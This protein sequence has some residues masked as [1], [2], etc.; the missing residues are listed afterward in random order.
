MCQADGEGEQ[1]DVDQRVGRRH[2]LG[3][4]RQVGAVEYGADQKYPGQQSE[5]QGHDRSVDQVGPVAI[6]AAGMNKHHHGDAEKTVRGQ[7]EDI[8]HRRI[9]KLAPSSQRVGVPHDEP[10]QV[11]RLAGEQN[12]PRPEARGPVDR[13]AH[14]HGAERGCVH[15][16]E[17]HPLSQRR[18]RQ[19]Q[20]AHRGHEADGHEAKAMLWV[21]KLAL[22]GC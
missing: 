12:R 20:E 6:G 19:D 1:H 15:R 13:Y 16:H 10:H 2:R 9:G 17:Q 8:G 22:R 21:H 11:Q 4:R 18:Q 7:K 5:T 3:Q 14:G